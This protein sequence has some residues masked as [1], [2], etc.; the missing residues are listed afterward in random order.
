MARIVG[1][2]FE[3]TSH[4]Q[5]GHLSVPR[6]VAALLGIGDNDPIEARVLW[7]GQQIELS[8]RLASG[9]ELYVR[10]SDPTTE[11]LGSLPPK[12]PILVT[13]WA[14]EEARD[15]DEAALRGRDTPWT[16]GEF[17]QAFEERVGNTSPLDRLMQWAADHGLKHRYGSG[18]TGPMY[19]DH[20]SMF[21]ISLANRGY[22]EIVV[23]GNLDS[24]APFASA[25][26]RRELL[27]VVLKRTGIQRDEHVADTWFGMGTDVL[28]EPARL[29]GL[30][31]VLDWLVEQLGPIGPESGAGGA[32]YAGLTAF[33]RSHERS[34]FEITF[35][36]IESLIATPLPPSSRRHAAHW[37]GAS[38][39]VS[40]AIQDAGW[41]AS[42][43]DLRGERLT[44]LPAPL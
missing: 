13:V 41:K 6:Q 31:S 23:Q 28:T 29:D 20:G 9:L 24:R 12:T 36:E 15:A 43:V 26:A 40:R 27:D 39:A 3:T 38:S 42:R 7:E 2:T 32:K 5:P 33:L 34:A 37:Y 30:V 17:R 21:L 11:G 19:I 25:A 14:S 10:K 18:R 35:A 1:V 22:A 4:A 16:D 8:T 44:F